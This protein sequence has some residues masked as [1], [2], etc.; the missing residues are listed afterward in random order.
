MS[1]LALD[2]DVEA[3]VDR[4][5]TRR[6]NASEASLERRLADRMQRLNQTLALAHMEN[7]L[8]HLN[9]ELAQSRE[10][11]AEQGDE[12]ERM[13]AAAATQKVC[14]SLPL[15]LSSR[16][17]SLARARTG[18]TFPP[19]VEPSISP[20]LSFNLYLERHSTSFF[21]PFQLF[22]TIPMV[23]TYLFFT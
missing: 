15:S 4:L 22:S 1:C 9:E 16:F 11:Q 3:A 18:R 6:L 8:Q 21:G 13:R 23:F 10:Q 20:S 5:V 7:L 2:A 17:T 14:L 19:L 12:L